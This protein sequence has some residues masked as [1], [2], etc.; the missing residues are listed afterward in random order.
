MA[1][2]EHAPPEPGPA[3]GVV[4]EAVVA[5]RRRPEAAW[6]LGTGIGGT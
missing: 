1:V 5:G 3:V 2:V 4:E 6:R